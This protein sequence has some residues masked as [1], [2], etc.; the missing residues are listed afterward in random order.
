MY[1]IKQNP[2]FKEMLSSEKS[3]NSNLAILES[4][5]N[6]K[7]ENQILMEFKQLIPQL[8]TISDGLVK[9]AEEV[10]QDEQLL[11]RRLQR[12]Q[13]L[14]AFYEAYEKYSSL[15]LKFIKND[16]DKTKKDCENIELSIKNSGSP[17]DFA[18][19]AAAPFQRGCKYNLLVREILKTP[20]IAS[21]NREELEKLSKFIDEQ[22]KRINN[23][24]KTSKKTYKF[25]DYTLKLFNAVQEIFQQDNEPQGSAYKLGDVTRGSLSFA[26]SFFQ[27][28]TPAPRIEDSAKDTLDVSDFTEI[29]KS[30]I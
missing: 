19:L 18:A 27:K 5:L 23:S 16:P 21:E 22:L 7:Y 30:S 11:P 14:K 29:E 12:V 20:E 6:G 3:Y 1:S 4:A 2:V 17:L 26:I 13:L 10:E 9:N 25:G 8:K 15:Y 24:M 28:T